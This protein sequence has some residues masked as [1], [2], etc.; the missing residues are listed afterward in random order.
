M[1]IPSLLNFVT[2]LDIESLRLISD[3]F[4]TVIQSYE[5][6]TGFIEEMDKYYAEVS[7]S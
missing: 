6:G 3:K 2:L 4:D 1:D 7:E 5:L